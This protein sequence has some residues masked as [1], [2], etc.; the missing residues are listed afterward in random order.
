MSADTFVRLELALG[1]G[2]GWSV[3]LGAEGRYSVRRPTFFYTAENGSES[4]AFEKPALS[5]SFDIAIAREF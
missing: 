4:A 3:P 1:L 5:G 2:R